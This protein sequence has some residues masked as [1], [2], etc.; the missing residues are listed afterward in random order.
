M[1]PIHTPPAALL[2]LP[3]ET[4]R[5]LRLIH[6]SDARAQEAGMEKAR[7]GFEH[8]IRVDVPPSLS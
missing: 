2:Q 7:A 1:P 8:T 3:E 4:R 5:N 6:L